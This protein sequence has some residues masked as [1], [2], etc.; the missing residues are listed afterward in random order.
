MGWIILVILAVV[1]FAGVASK[2]YMHRGTDMSQAQLLQRIEKKSDICILDVRSA[3]EYSSGYVP[4][5]INIG[6]KEISV[7]SN[8]VSLDC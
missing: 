3:H 8:A 5:A 6:H 7:Y 1:V 2:L 4:G